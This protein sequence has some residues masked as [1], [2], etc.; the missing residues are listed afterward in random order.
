MLCCRIRISEKEDLQMMDILVNQSNRKFF[1]HS[2]AKM[3]ESEPEYYELK[4]K[5]TK[6]KMLVNILKKTVNG[7][8]I[9]V[10]PNA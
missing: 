2:L 6:F 7:I 5:S 3:R 4:L 10:H 9:E 8:A 1:L